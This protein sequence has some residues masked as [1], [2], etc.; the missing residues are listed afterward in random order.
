MMRKIRLTQIRWIRWNG[1]R[2][3]GL[4]ILFLIPFLS[5][6]I[7]IVGIDA[8]SSN[9]VNVPY[10]VTLTTQGARNASLLSRRARWWW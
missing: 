9:T 5:G 3:L 6:R 8:V 4:A 7:D 1:G 10:C 2:F